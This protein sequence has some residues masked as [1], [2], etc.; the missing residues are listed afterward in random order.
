M[1]KL[2]IFSGAGFI[3]FVL[4]AVMASLVSQQHGKQVDPVPY[5]PV[6]V[7][8]TP[9]ESSANEMVRT[10]PKLPDTQPP[11]MQTAVMTSEVDSVDNYHYQ[12]VELNLEHSGGGLSTFTG[13]R[14]GDARPLVRTN[15][16]Y[17]VEAAR[18]GIEGWV[19]MSFDI[20]ELGEVT[21]IEVIDAEPKRVFNRAAKQALRKWKYRAKVV[22]GKA[23]IQHGMTV[24]LDFNMQNQA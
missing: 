22:D 14:E 16:T 21:N 2:T 10:L 5:V 9:P 17:P 4:F 1:K 3:T 6:T 24:Q 13:L 19:M 11:K 15:P 20:N 12:P 18:D 7:M 23:V 8:Q